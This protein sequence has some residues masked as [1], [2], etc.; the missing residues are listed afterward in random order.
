MSQDTRQSLERLAKERLAVRLLT[1]DLPTMQPSA[2]KHEYL[3]TV[4]NVLRNPVASEV[5]EQGAHHIIGFGDFQRTLPLVVIRE[6]APD[7][8]IRHA[9]VPSANDPRDRRLLAALQDHENAWAEERGARPRDIA[10]QIRNDGRGYVNQH[11]LNRYQPSPF[12]REDLDEAMHGRWYPT[13][14]IAPEHEIDH[15]GRPH[16]ADQTRLEANV[17]HSAQRATT[18]ATTVVGARVRTI[19]KHNTLR[20]ESLDFDEPDDDDRQP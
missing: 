14:P 13:S 6:T 16:P 11:G 3:T 17:A 9:F 2:L 18:R 12:T 19:D 15:P 1:R 4:A 7:S 20:L 8:T 5:D 10:G